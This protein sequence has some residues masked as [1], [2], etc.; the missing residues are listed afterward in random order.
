MNSLSRNI[1]FTGLSLGSIGIIQ[2]LIL[3]LHLPFIVVVILSVAACILLGRWINK[4]NAITE[5]QQEHKRFTTTFFIACMVIFTNKAYYL[6]SSKHGLWDAWYIWDLHSRYLMDSNNWQQMLLNKEGAHPDY[7]I[8][9][10]ALLAFAKQLFFFIEGWVVNYAVHF[11]ITLLIPVIIFTETYK[12]SIFVSGLVLILFVTN[13]FYITQGLIQLADTLLAM[14]FLFALISINNSKEDKRMIGISA[15]FL[16]LCMLTK[17]EGIIIAAIFILFHAKTFFLKGN[18]KPFALGIAIPLLTWGLF[19]TVYAPTND[20]VSGQN[21]DTWQLILDTD[22]YKLIYNSFVANFKEHFRDIRYGITFYLFFLAIK[23]KWPDKQIVMVF[24]ICV[25]YMLIYVV[26][27]YDLEWHLF[28]SQSRLMHQLM[29]AMMYVLATKFSS[30][31]NTN[32]QLA[33][34]SIPKR[35]Q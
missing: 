35:P 2:F 22:R 13:D 28:T 31:I 34:F 23:G 18:L 4:G 25:V 26:S 14:F 7:P 33:S 1:L 19:K 17:N 32:F 12:K 21:A 6:S 30:G 8:V 15:A 9:L 11:L 5:E 20:M 24:A 16:G 29:P 3:A 10:P 27:P